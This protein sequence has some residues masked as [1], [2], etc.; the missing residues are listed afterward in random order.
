MGTGHL[1][2]GGGI[3]RAD[4]DDLRLSLEVAVSYLG[5]GEASTVLPGGAQLLA[6]Q[7]APL[8]LGGLG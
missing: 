1:H 4:G 5:G 2:S 6:L 3:H 7:E 8:A